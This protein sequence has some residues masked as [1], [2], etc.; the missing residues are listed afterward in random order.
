MGPPLTVRA[1]PRAV[2]MA[3]SI[4]RLA[5]TTP[6]FLVSHRAFRDLAAELGGWGRAADYLRE[7][8]EANDRPLAVNVEAGAGTSR[9]AFIAPKHWTSERL[10]GWVGGRRE[11]LERELGPIERITSEGRR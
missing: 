8:V 7:L 11:L 1:D 6:L 2:S 10:L 9:T 5:G 4:A 3:A